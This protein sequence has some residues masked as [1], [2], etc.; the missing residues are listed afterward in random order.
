MKWFEFKSL[1][2]AAGV[3]D[4]T[5]LFYGDMQVGSESNAFGIN[6]VIVDVSKNEL[7]ILTQYYPFIKPCP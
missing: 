2:E 7:R 1:L 5:E 6:D 4:D 3:K